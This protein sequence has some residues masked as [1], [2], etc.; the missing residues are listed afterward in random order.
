MVQAMKKA[1]E[2][3]KGGDSEKHR[4]T[5][6]FELFFTSHLCAGREQHVCLLRVGLSLAVNVPFF[7]TVGNEDGKLAREHNGRLEE[8][9]RK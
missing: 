9:V 2:I 5:I 6:H 4:V 8:W 3:K 7:Y 1:E